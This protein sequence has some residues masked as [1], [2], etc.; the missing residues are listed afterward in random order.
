MRGAG[1][2]STSKQPPPLG[3]V[4][5]PLRRCTR[6]LHLDGEDEVLCGAAGVVHVDWGEATGFL[7]AAHRADLERWGSLQHH[8]L[9]PC[10]GMPGSLWYAEPNVCAYPDGELPVAEPARA[11]AEEAAA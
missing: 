2:V 10:C 3:R 11:V 5:E 7:C 6:L 1:S 4:Y 8:K 9:G